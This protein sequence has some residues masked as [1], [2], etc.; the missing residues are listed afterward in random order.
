VRFDGRRIYSALAVLLLSLSAGERSELEGSAELVQPEPAPSWPTQTRWRSWWRSGLFE[1][2]WFAALRGQFVRPVDAEG[3]PASLLRMFGGSIRDQYRSLLC[4]LS[5]L[6]TR[7]VPLLSSQ[8]A[9][10]N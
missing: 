2:A 8:S 9:M 6:T 1:T 4:A 5:P 10:A 3:S 7:S